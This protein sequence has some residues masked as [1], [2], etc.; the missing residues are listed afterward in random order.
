M[1]ANVLAL[2]V[3]V[4][5]FEGLKSFHMDDGLKFVVT[6]VGA[7]GADYIL[8]ATLAAVQYATSKP[9]DFLIR[10]VKG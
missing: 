4:M 1:R 8:R 7:V 5:C 10:I 3:A 6:S 2:F 9:V